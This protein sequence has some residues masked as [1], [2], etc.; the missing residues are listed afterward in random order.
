MVSCEE[1]PNLEYVGY[2]TRFL[3]GF[4]V[5]EETLV[6]FVGGLRRRALA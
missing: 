5:S 3:S 1:S 6:D 4:C 2:G